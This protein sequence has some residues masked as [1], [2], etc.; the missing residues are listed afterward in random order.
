VNNIS[1]LLGAREIIVSGTPTKVTSRSAWSVICIV[2]GA[3]V[4]V[5][6]G[7]VV[8]GDVV[9]TGGVVVGC[10]VAGGVVDGVVVGCVVVVVVG[11]VVV[12]VPLQDTRI[13]RSSIAARKINPVLLI[14][15]FTRT[16]SR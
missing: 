10:V 1:V 7:V 6:G 16:S 12:S 14:M 3:G 2:G 15:L 8:G 4:V 9:V 5:T 11:V 13:V